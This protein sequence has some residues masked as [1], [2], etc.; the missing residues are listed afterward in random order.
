MIIADLLLSNCP[1][2]GP[3]AKRQGMGNNNSLFQSII[4]SQFDCGNTEII[5]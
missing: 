1:V 3:T 4:L 2:P 5:V